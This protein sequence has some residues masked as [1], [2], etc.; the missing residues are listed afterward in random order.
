MI[1]YLII[2][3][4]IL[5]TV[6]TGIRLDVNSSPRVPK[7]PSDF[8]RPKVVTLVRSGTRPR[9]I[10]RLLLN[11]RNA[12]SFEHA[13]SSITDAVKLDTGA[14][15]KVYNMAGNQ[16]YALQQFFEFESVFFVYGSERF[17]P[18]DLHLDS[19]GFK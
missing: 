14:V 12:R 2:K 18:D 1:L 4:F 16:I 11:K 5:F 19:E 6:I 17:N 8:I 3:S 15:R 9:K 13:L 7:T 10:I